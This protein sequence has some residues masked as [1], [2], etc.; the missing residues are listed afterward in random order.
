MPTLRTDTAQRTLAMFHRAVQCSGDGVH[1]IDIGIDRK[2]E[3][4]RSVQ[5]PGLPCL[6]IC[7]ERSHVVGEGRA[8]GVVGGAEV[9][10]HP[11]L[12]ANLDGIVNIAV[13][14]GEF[15][16]MLSGVISANSSPLLRPAP[17]SA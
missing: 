5:I 13:I 1:G 10:T 6:V 11:A 12:V 15:P 16:C 3:K 9:L 4:V 2:M 7:H 17:F 14:V 8:I